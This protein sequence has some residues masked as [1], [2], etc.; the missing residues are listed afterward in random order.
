MAEE[1]EGLDFTPDDAVLAFEEADEGIEQET[2][3]EGDQ[4]QSRAAAGRSS[5]LT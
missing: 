4:G 5:R 1:T 3:R 2:V